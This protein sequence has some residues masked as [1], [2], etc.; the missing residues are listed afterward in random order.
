[1]TRT[2]RERAPR[3]GRKAGGKAPALC[4]GP[5]VEPGH[6]GERDLSAPA[7]PVPARRLSPDLA[8][9]LA[10]ILAQALLADLI[11]GPGP[12]TSSGASGRGGGEEPDAPT[13]SR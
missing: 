11:E 13:E 4:A 6:P 10:E 1:M 12:P 9:A 7:P 2:D 3:R 8:A 5:A